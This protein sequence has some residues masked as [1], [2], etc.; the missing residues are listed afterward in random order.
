MKQQTKIPILLVCSAVAFSG[1]SSSSNLRKFKD[2]D[3]QK[4]IPVEMAKKFEVRDT[5]SASPTPTPVPVVKKTSSV[6]RKKIK[7][8][9]TA[10]VSTPL[11]P[12]VRKISPMPF[13]VGEKLNYDIRYVGVTAGYFNTEVMPFKV[14]NDRKVYHFQAHAKTVKLFELVY[15]VND[16]LESFWDEEGAF[17]HRFTMDLDESKQTRKLIELYDYDKKKSFFWN[18][19]DHVQ[20][21]FSEQK[22]QYDIALW[23]QDPISSLYYLRIAPLPKDPNQEFRF[24]IILDGKPWEGVIHFLGKERVYAGGRYFESNVY[25]LE[26]YQNG[27]VK[28][29]DNKVW[30]SDDEHR[31]VLRVEAKI[32]VGSFAVALDKIL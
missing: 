24:P 19:I 30:I 4:E 21:G 17:S 27:E 25:K 6:R 1:C 5:S 32:K 9:E 16:L 14:V 22:E 10:K 18:R 2:D 11:I 15:R 20:K 8:K 31:Y 12:P 13:D 28:N 3:L 29:K 7:V 23:S 26:N